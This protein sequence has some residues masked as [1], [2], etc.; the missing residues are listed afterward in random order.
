[1]AKKVKVVRDD[2]YEQMGPAYQCVLADILEA[3][4]RENG[5]KSKTQRQEI[6]ESFMFA[7]G[8]FHDTGWMRSAEWDNDLYPMPA[9]WDGR[10]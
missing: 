10:L 1:M 6:V 9:K 3:S 2:A 8:E 5:V 7:V 4:L